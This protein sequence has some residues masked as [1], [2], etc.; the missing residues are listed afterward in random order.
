[1]LCFIPYNYAISSRYEQTRFCFRSGLELDIGMLTRTGWA[2]VRLTFCPGV[3]EA[4]AVGAVAVLLFAMPVGLTAGYGVKKGIP[5]IVVAAASFDD[6]VAITGMHCS[7][8]CWM[9]NPN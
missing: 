2:A 4:L 7:D 9:Y 8:C 6:V 5:S 3:A 1:M